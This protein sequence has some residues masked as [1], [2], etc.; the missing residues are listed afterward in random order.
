MLSESAVIQKL[1]DRFPAYIGDDAAVIPS[2]NHSQS[3]VVTKDLLLENIHFRTGYFNPA[4]L[5]H[6]ALHANLSD[7][8]AMGAKPHFILCGIG[9]PEMHHAY[10][11]AFLSSLTTACQA[12]GV[13]LIGGD[14]TRSTQ[15][16]L[17]SITA[18]GIADSHHI[19]YRTNAKVGNYLCVAGYLGYA[20]IGL[21]ALERADP[22][23]DEYKQACLKPQAKV[24]EGI[25]L[26]SKSSV[27]SM[28]D[29][30]DGLLI[31]T[32]QLCAQSQVGGIIHI[33]ELP[34]SPGWIKACS[35][36]AL[37]PVI[38]LLTGG[39]DY[40]LLFTLDSKEY[41]E[42]AREFQHHFGYAILCVG[43]IIEGSEVQ[44]LE[45]GHPYHQP[46]KPFTH[47]GEII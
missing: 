38:T 20:H 1:I 40:S 4:D 35:A 44:I 26:S 2:I 21:T 45:K 5:A 8:A 37:D 31:S 43:Q 46:I 47:F 15:D 11:Q 32:Q 16:L 36:L 27:T 22:D 3:Y 42:I 19:K 9:I 39:E 41:L 17:I 23:F 25:W 33:E 10:G 14:T 7:I 29:I 13:F 24:P 28:M 18:I 34:Q 12:A 30:S 6:K